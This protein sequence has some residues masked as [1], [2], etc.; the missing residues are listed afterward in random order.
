MATVTRGGHCPSLTVTSITLTSEIFVN[1]IHK[2]NNSAIIDLLNEEAG[3]IAI[4]NIR[5][6]S[7]ENALMIACRYTQNEEIIN[8]L[9]DS[10][11]FDPGDT[12]NLGETALMIAC[13]VYMHNTETH[14]S[15]L[16]KLIAFTGKYMNVHIGYSSALQRLISKLVDGNYDDII[17]EMIA[18]GYTGVEDENTYCALYSACLKSTPTVVNAILDVYLRSN[19]TDWANLC[20]VINNPLVASI[21]RPELKDASLTII[22]MITDAGG[23]FDHQ[24][25]YINLLDNSL[26]NSLDKYNGTSCYNPCYISPL[27]HAC[28]VQNEPVILALLATGAVRVDLILRYD[29]TLLADVIW[30]WNK[31]S[32][33]VIKA[34]FSAS[35]TD[36]GKY[37]DYYGRSYLAMAIISGRVDLVKFLISTGKFDLRSEPCALRIYHTSEVKKEDYRDFV[38]RLWRTEE[39]LKYVPSVLEAIDR[40]ITIADEVSRRFALLKAKFG[41]EV[42]KRLAEKIRAYHG[43]GDGAE[44]RC[45]VQVRSLG[46]EFSLFIA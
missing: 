2:C 7:M 29:I 16:R 10:G 4:K 3:R 20:K 22:S 37:R 28:N 30:K 17:L 8:V 14:K 43:C 15:I 26:D 19:K 41:E 27:V 18:T 31:K 9:I 45:G 21:K 33:D 11:L 1:L 12:N 40:E 13:D 25:V 24:P 5:N 34:L 32:S 36:Y 42:E 44:F 38:L 35:K 46:A 6:T 23:A 39:E